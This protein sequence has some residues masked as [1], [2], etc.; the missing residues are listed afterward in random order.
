VCLTL[1]ALTL[2]HAAPATDKLPAPLLREPNYER[3]PGY[4]LLLL[5]AGQPDRVWIVLDGRSLYI[6]RN[7][8]GDLTD[9]GPPVPATNERSFDLSEGTSWDRSYVLDEFAPSIG[10][11]HRDF[12]LRQWNYSDPEDRFGLSLTLDGRVPMYAGWNP[13]LA[14]SAAEAPV[15]HFGR[16]VRPRMLRNNSLTIGATPRRFSIAFT[17]P[18]FSKLAD[19]RLSIEALPPQAHPTVQ[20]DW[21]VAEGA[22]PVRTDHVLDERCCYWEFYTTRFQVPAGIVPGVA[23]GT[24]N[25]PPLAF[26]L[27][28]VEER[29]EIPVLAGP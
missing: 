6:D 3:Q 13:L 25:V 8:N 17:N 10:R 22:Q 12:H 27:E 19:A 15:I 20:I 24:V 18:D 21:P 5:G 16:S 9:D 26:P 29:L 2:C 23:R 28:L 11:T 4:A 7:A 1:A 14:T